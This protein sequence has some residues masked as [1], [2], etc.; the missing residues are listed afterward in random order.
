M[1]E[2]KER[3]GEPEVVDDDKETTSSRHKG[4]AMRMNS[5]NLPA[6]ERRYMYELRDYT[7][8]TEPIHL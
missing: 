1:K 3:L 4:R 7:S 5:E 2:E 8:T 6:Q